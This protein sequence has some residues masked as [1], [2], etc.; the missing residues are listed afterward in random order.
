MDIRR[1][2]VERTEGMKAQTIEI[3]FKLSVQPNSFEATTYGRINIRKSMKERS[4]L[5]EIL[6][7]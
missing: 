4:D 5:G 3:I 7:L 2:N 1:K 6:R